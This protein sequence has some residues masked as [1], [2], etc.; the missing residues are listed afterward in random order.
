[1]LS[2]TCKYIALLP[3]E[4]TSLRTLKVICDFDRQDFKIVDLNVVKFE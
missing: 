4:N 3:H 1:M 2:E